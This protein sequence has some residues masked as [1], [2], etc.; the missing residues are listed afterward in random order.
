MIEQVGN[1]SSIDV[2]MKNGVVILGINCGGA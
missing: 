1:T 2:I